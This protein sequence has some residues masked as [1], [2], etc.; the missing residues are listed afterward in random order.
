M[1]TSPDASYS[2]CGDIMT[3]NDLRPTIC[4]KVRLAGDNSSRLFWIWRLAENCV[5]TKLANLYT[6]RDDGI[7]P[8]S[9]NRLSTLPP[10]IANWGVWLGQN[11]DCLLRYLR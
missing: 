9:P 2:A 10:C 3:H 6:A 1:R 5:P 8:M 7:L 4:E 11:S